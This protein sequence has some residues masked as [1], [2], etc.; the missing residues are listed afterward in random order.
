MRLAEPAA[1]AA[2]VLSFPVCWPS[3]AAGAVPVGVHRPIRGIGASARVRA[4]TAGRISPHP[5]PPLL[6]RRRSPVASGGRGS[7]R[8]GAGIPWRKSNSSG[9]RSASPSGTSGKNHLTR[10]ELWVGFSSLGQSDSSRLGCF[11]LHSSA[12]K[13]LL[14]DPAGSHIEHSLADT[15][16]QAAHLYLAVVS[17]FRLPILFSKLQRSF[18]LHEAWGALTLRTQ[19]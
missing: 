10:K 13:E 18:A 12:F 5:V 4:I 14:R 1:I 17:Q 2:L 19:A 3:A 16:N 8:V 6:C 7:A 15:G 11:E 9:V